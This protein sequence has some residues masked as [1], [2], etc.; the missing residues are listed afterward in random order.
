MRKTLPPGRDIPSNIAIYWVNSPPVIL[1]LRK[2]ATFGAKYKPKHC[3]IPR[4]NAPFLS[5][6][7]TKIT[8]N[9]A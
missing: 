3:V 9:Y 2:T 7:Y 5:C 4:Y 6:L 1:K 8:S